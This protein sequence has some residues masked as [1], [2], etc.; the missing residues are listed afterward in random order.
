MIELNSEEEHGI[1]PARERGFRL[2]L[3]AACLVVVLAGM[4]AAAS[5]F[6]PVVLAFFLSVLSYP[7]MRWL[8]EHRVPHW[9][10][11]LVTVTVN[12]G[13]LV[14]VIQAGVHLLT[15]MQHE[16]P[17]YIK[18]MKGLL[19][20]GAIW[21]QNQGAAEAPAMLDQMWDWQGL[22]NNQNIVQGLTTIMGST[23]GT[24]ASV[25][26]T[27][28]VVMIL[29]VF[30]LMEAV[31]TRGRLVAVKM[32]GGPDFG[33]LLESASDI[34]KYLVIKTSISIVTGFLAGVWCWMFDLP[35]AVLWGIVAFLMNYIPA[36][37]SIMAGVPPVLLALV[38][39]GFGSAFGVMLGYLGINT[40]LGTFL[41]PLLL[42]R[43]FGA[44]PL[45]IVTSVIFWGWMWGPVGM[46]L[47]VP[48]TMMVKMMLGHS[49]EFR[50]MAVAMAKKKVK[51]GEVVLM[52]DFDLDG[53][54]SE[55]L[56]GGAST[57][58]RGGRET[59][60]K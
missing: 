18:G 1:H 20:Q 32:A 14:F 23:V 46:F 42:G 8:R 41:E 9:M 29:M 60:V 51:K 21:L 38:T 58:F 7:M 16:L 56:G 45:V 13:V 48:L 26:S 24:A 44:S 22:G 15:R 36:V 59:Q 50:W 52:A 19:D 12:V 37:G 27:T 55:L 53:E 54:E 40:A 34:Q 3:T 30:I 49:D 6:V 4:K 39:S 47:A 33:Q 31:G 11:V 43:R 25:V 28:T 10:G 2:L 17:Y 5:F 35:Y 57:E